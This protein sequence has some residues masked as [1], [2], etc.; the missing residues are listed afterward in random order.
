MYNVEQFSEMAENGFLKQAP[1]FA[2]RAIH[3]GQDPERWNSYCVVPP[4]VT[5]TTFKQE[6]PGKH[7]VKK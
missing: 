3:V 7:R 5:S 6:A 2:T 4:L 1:G